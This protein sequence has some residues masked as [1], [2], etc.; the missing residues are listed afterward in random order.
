MYAREN[1][2][3]LHF[4]KASLDSFLPQKYHLSND[5]Q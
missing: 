1:Y 2:Q 5:Y 4:R 3:M